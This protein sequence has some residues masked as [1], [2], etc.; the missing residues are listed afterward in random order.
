VLLRAVIDPGHDAWIVEN[1]NFVAYEFESKSADEY[2]KDSVRGELPAGRE[3]RSHSERKRARA[4]SS[5]SQAVDL[6]RSGFR[7]PMVATT[8]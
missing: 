1:E 8:S 5:G 2:A 7:H 4:G 6:S 3:S